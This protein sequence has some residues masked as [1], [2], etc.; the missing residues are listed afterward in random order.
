[1]PFGTITAQ[2]KAYEPRSEGTYTLST[3]TFGQPD[4]SFVIRPASPK[5][6]VRRMAVSRIH[7]KDIVIGGETERITATVTVNVVVPQS[8]FTAEELDS[9]VSDIAE[10]LNAG[11]ITRILLGEQ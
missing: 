4:N 5:T 10:F 9:S 6:D 3:V 7:Q 8:G 2:T 1:M 11:T